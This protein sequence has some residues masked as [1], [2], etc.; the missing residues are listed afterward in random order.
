MKKTLTIIL[1]LCL[2]NSF[3]QLQK[4]IERISAIR[5]KSDTT[6]QNTV[7][8]TDSIKDLIVEK[9]FTTKQ[10]SE[11]YLSNIC[12]TLRLL[13]L[14]VSCK[15]ITDDKLYNIVIY[16]YVNINHKH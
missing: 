16:K 7:V 13:N 6:I 12:Y 1:T 5:N 3:S 10:E 11:D 2:L 9:N 14:Y 8:L 15:Y 4:K